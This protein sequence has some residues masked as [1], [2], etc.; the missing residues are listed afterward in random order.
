MTTKDGFETE[1]LDDFAKNLLKLAQD[2]FPKETY[3]F[4]RKSG[5]KAR[6]MTARKA[7]SLVNKETGKYHKSFK[8]GKAYFRR[9]SRSYEIQ[10]RNSSPHAHLIEYGHILT[11]ENGKVIGFV[12]GYHVM[13]KSSKEF[14]MK[15]KGLIEDWLDDL[16]DKGL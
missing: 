13:E 8:R 5:S 12:P 4:M 15:F 3:S 10:I 6:T 9:S 16:I 2:E 7:R 1:E 14:N 11:S